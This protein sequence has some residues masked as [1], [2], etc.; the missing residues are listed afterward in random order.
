MINKNNCI[1]VIDFA[2]GFIKCLYFIVKFCHILMNLMFFL[3]NQIIFKR[4]RI[5]NNHFFYY[6]IQNV[7][8]L[9]TILIE[10][11]K[12]HPR[13]ENNRKGIAKQ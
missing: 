4:K 5:L 3:H 1:I 11:E 12:E 2:S 10:I 6:Y 7:Y 13:K 9:V 8:N